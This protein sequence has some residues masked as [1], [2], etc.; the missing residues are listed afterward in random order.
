VDYYISRL[1]ELGQ[2]LSVLYV[3]DEPAIQEETRLLLGKFFARVDCANNGEE[4]LGLYSSNAYDL[5]ITDIA[6]PIINGLEM[7]EQIKQ[8][9]RDQIIIIVTAYTNP[10][11]FA[12]AVRIGVGGFILKPAQP[13]QI[14][15][16]LYDGAI[17]V[18]ESKQNRTYRD[19]LES[20]V[21]ERT[22]E[23]L[24]S[25]ITD[26]LTGLDNYNKLKDDLQ[27]SVDKAVLLLNIDNFDSINNSF[28]VEAGDETLL[29]AAEALKLLIPDGV[30]LYRTHGD[31]FAI[32]L[33]GDGQNAYELALEIRAFFSQTKLSVRAGDQS[34]SF[35][36][37]ID[38]GNSS[39]I[40]KNAKIAI[41][42]VRALGKDR[43]QQYTPDT[44]YAKEQKSR[45]LWID[46]SRTAI[47][48]DLFTP[49]FQPIIDNKTDI[50][51]KYEAL[52]R[53]R[54]D[55]QIIPPVKFIEPAKLAGLLPAITRIMLDKSFA[56]F[57]THDGKFSVNIGD[58]DIKEGYLLKFLEQKLARYNLDP[59][60]VTLEILE[61]ISVQ[62]AKES[63]SQLR[64]LK[65]MGFALAIDDFGTE[66][67]NFSRLLD[68]DVDYIKIDGCFI[69]NLDRDKNSQK[70]T[71][72]IVA[73][74]HSIGA[75]VIAEFVHNE[76]VFK[77]VKAYEIEYSQGYF[78]GQ[79]N[80]TIEVKI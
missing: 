22:D 39:E 12:Q 66:N 24:K 8:K 54:F 62:D 63:L 19:S 46:R 70:I 4:G 31:E 74:A 53:M 50:I 79:P 64:E 77:A 35:T 43:I 41:R 5:V 21:K 20:L 61:T 11:Y 13:A 55:E 75:K 9:N 27:C 23:L 17:R 36:I 14:L 76:A 26:S 45:L 34:I 40:L 58:Y 72:S 56:Y 48:E 68:L 67:S 15:S 80:D 51:V 1:K 3:E 32:L 52:A 49:Y 60:R 2:N 30:T 25:Y 42:E 18:Y 57:A 33:Q 10:D 16:A 7:A 6:M 47:S 29:R 28:G 78:I 44:E 37:G 69:K 59:H 38:S 71:A 65:S 73:F